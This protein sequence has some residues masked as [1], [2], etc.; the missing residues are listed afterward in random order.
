MDAHTGNQR[1]G[2]A[3]HS[4]LAVEALRAARA[5]HRLGSVLHYL[6]STGST[7][8]VARELALDGAPEG[9]TVIAEQ[10]TRGRGRLGRSWVSPPFRNLH[11]SVVLRPRIEVTRAPQISLVA[12]LAAAE[13]VGEWAADAAIKWPNDIVVRGRK[14]A[15]L[16]AEMEAAEQTIAFVIVGIGVNLNC[17]AADFPPELR[18]KAV[19]VSTVIGRPIDRVAFTNSLL[20]RLEERYDTYLQHGFGAL[21]PS[22]EALS[23]LTGRRVQID[24]GARRFEGIVVGMADDGTLRLTDEAQHEHTVVAGDVT[25]IDGYEAISKP[26]PVARKPAGA[27]V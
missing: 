23:A 19:A 20:S 22:W 26:R 2:P 10:Q 7:N 8:D 12:G 24:D 25:V 9:T 3:L 14:V 15:G 6:E 21:R 1:F 27:D 4:P 16:L 5:G 13:A 18:D 11:L 17:T